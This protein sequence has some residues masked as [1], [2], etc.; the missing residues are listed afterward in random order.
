LHALVMFMVAVP[1]FVIISISIC[2]RSLSMIQSDIIP[3]TCRTYTSFLCTTI[4]TQYPVWRRVIILPPWPRQSQ[5]ATKREPGA[6][7]Y[8]WATLSLG[9]INTETWS[10]RLGGWTQGWRHWSVKKIIVAKSKEMKT[11][12][13]N[14]RQIWQNLLRKTKR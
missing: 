13:S 10:S 1:K 14:S 3:G 9:N 2:F 7:G 8:N 5:K 4:I 11:G 6:W 12:W